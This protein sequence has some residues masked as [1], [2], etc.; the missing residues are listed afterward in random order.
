MYELGNRLAG[1]TEIGLQLFSDAL[2]LLTDL[3]PFDHDDLKRIA[4]SVV[5]LRSRGLKKITVYDCAY[6]HLARLSGT[7]LITADRLQARAAKAL[8]IPGLLLGD[9]R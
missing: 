6:I 2:V 9:Y 7:P 3:V 5:G 1:L 8:G 4:E